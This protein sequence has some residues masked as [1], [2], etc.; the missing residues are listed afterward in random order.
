MCLAVEYFQIHSV[1]ITEKYIFETC[2]SPLHD[3]II[4]P[5]VKHLPINL[6]KKVSPMQSFFKKKVP[7]YFPG[8]GGGDTMLYCHIF[9]HLFQKFLR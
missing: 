9:S 5:H 7:P 4:S 3:L 6:L 8:G 2:P 1:Q